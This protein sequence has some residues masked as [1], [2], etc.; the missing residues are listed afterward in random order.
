MA[1]DTGF[2]PIALRDY[3][4]DA[5]AAVIADVK[6]GTRRP[7]VV[8]ATGL[9]KTIV[10]AD[11]VAKAKGRVLVI[12]H[13]I[14]LVEQAAQK[15][16]MVLGPD[17]DIG[18]VKAARD[19]TSARYVVASIQTITREKRRERLGDFCL[20]IVDE[21]HH[22][23]AD[24]YM[25]VM[26]SYPNTV[27]VGFT[28]TPDRG[29]RLGLQTNGAFEKVS[30]HMGILDGI[31]GQWLCDLRGLTVKVDIDTRSVRVSQGDL[32]GNQL[33]RVLIDAN[34]PR[35]LA[36]AYC[37]HAGDRKGILFAPNV[38]SSQAFAE[39]LNDAGIIAEHLDGTTAAF[40]R[41]A[42][43]RRLKI[44]D[45]QVVSN[46]AVLT[47]GFDEPSVSCIAIARPTRS[48]PLYQQ[49][50]GRGTRQSIGKRD[51]LVLDLV[52][53]SADHS[54]AS[55]PVITGL[56]KMADGAS[57]SEAVA[58]D[59]S[60]GPEIPADVL[61]D[62]KRARLSSAPVDLFHRANLNWRP[63]IGDGFPEGSHKIAF[64][65]GE[66]RLMP[67]PEADGSGGA[68]L[69][70]VQEALYGLRDSGTRTYL[71]RMMPESYALGVAEDYIRD[72][73]LATV[74][75]KDAR[76]LKK[77][78]SEK[79]QAVL[80]KRGLWVDGITQGEARDMIAEIAEREGWGGRNR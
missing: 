22:A 28:A 34:G 71:A 79:M 40:E 67:D 57:V 55:L 11:L 1:V 60:E 39:A 62:G 56:L 47:E 76:W 20:I 27:A 49:M 44:G 77:P 73:D 75:A 9:G 36:A 29:D 3:Q 38:V 10:F 35:A 72:R 4:N 32:D 6:A 37:E 58:M 48:R 61:I 26:A 50:V 14:E 24:S 54:L 68:D 31:K 23:V 70:C 5:V 25:R 78:A 64:P 15:M 17:A 51:C 46:C 74:A 65:G 2:H 33:G 63:M 21:A 16:R 30:Y 41:A 66:I 19:E 13:T 42:I 7:L 8:M 80:E 43:L 18:V 53:I 52:G 45:T 59:A 69:Y 12:A